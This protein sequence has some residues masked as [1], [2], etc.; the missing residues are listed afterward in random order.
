MAQQLECCLVWFRRDLR[1]YD[2]PALVA[3]L[4]SAKRVIPVYVWAPE[5]EVRCLAWRGSHQHSELGCPDTKLSEGHPRPL[6]TAVRRNVHLQHVSS[7][8]NWPFWLIESCS[9]S[10]TFTA[11]LSLFN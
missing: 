1:T 4:N 11:L 5:E 2:N 9:S 10:S 7:L 8:R 6:L 3:A